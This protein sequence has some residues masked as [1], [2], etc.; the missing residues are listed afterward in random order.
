MAVDPMAVRKVTGPMVFVLLLFILARLFYLGYTKMK[1]RNPS[2]RFLVYYRGSQN[3]WESFLKVICEQ[4]GLEYLAYSYEEFN[5]KLRMLGLS[6]SW[7]Q[8]LQK[9]CE[10][11][12]YGKYASGDECSD[13]RDWVELLKNLP[14]LKET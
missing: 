2:Q 3:T 8:S 14:S 5:E 10:R 12:Q 7:L 13:Y 1:L 11:E 4:Y 6:Q 9:L